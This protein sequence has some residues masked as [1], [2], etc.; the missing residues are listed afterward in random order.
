MEAPLDESSLPTSGVLASAA[1]QQPR[2]ARPN[3]QN[4]FRLRRNST[5]FAAA[6]PAIRTS[7]NSTSSES[8]E[9]E[10]NQGGGP[11][12]FLCKEYPSRPGRR[13]TIIHRGG[14]GMLGCPSLTEVWHTPPWLA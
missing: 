6:M 4:C 14:G 3:Q 7:A 11:C 9:V 13:L 1:D 12:Q 8:P 2:A 5:G 10:G